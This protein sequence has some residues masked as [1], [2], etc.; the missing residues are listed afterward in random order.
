MNRCS[1]S[2]FAELKGFLASCQSGEVESKVVKS[3]LL[4]FYSDSGVDSG[5][6]FALK[7]HYKL[8]GYLNFIHNH[9]TTRFNPIW[10][11]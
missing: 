3:P 9:T 11:G 8:E 1:P 4:Q 5:T 7:I 10:Q 2:L 6:C